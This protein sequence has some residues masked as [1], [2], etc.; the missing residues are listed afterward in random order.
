M[1]KGNIIGEGFNERIKKQVDARQQVFGSFNRSDN[2]LRYLNGNNAWIKLSSSVKVDP[3]KLNKIPDLK[4]YADNE[5]KLAQ[6]FVLFGGTAKDGGI[7]LR[8]GLK[9]AYSL[10]DNSQGFRPMPGITSLESKNR[11][12]GSIRETTVNIKAYNTTQFNIIDLLYL[13]L[14]YTV[15]LEWGHSIYINNDKEVIDINNSNTLSSSFVGGQFDNKQDE[16]FTKIKEKKLETYGNYDAIYGKVTNFSWNFEVDGSYT[17]TLKILSLGDIIE[18]LKVNTIRKD[19]PTSKEREKINEA[20]TDEEVI[21]A[22]KNKNAITKLFFDSFEAIDNDN[23]NKSY[24]TVSLELL[25]FGEV[26][27]ATLLPSDTIAQDLGYQFAGDFLQI[28]EADNGLNDTLY[29]VRFGGFCEYLKQNAVLYSKDNKAIINIDN[30][31]DSNLIFTNQYVI[32]SDPYKCIIPNN[33]TVQNVGWFDVWWSGATDTYDIFSELPYTFFKEVSGNLVGQLMNV[34]FNVSFIIK[35]MDELKDEEGNVSLY[36]LLN[37]L[38]STINECLGNLNKISVVIDEEDNN[39]I[40]FLDETQLPNREEIIEKLNPESKGELA[41][42]EIYG[43]KPDNASFVRN[44]SIKTEI[45]NELAS[46]ITIGAQANGNAA[47][48]DATAFSQWNKGLTDRIIPEKKAGKNNQ[49]SDAKKGEEIKTEDYEDIIEDYQSFAEK[50]QYQNFD[51]DVNYFKDTL[52]NMLELMQAKKSLEE[53]KA[54]PTSGFIPL[55]L[56]L[57]LFGLSGMKIYQKFSINQQ[58]LPYNYP[59]TIEF[60]IKGISHKVDKDGWITSIESLS[61]PKN[62]TGVKSQPLP[63]KNLSFTGT[64]IGT[65]KGITPQNTASSTGKCPVPSRNLGWPK[66]VPFQSTTLT[67]KEIVNI[68]KTII[69]NEKELQIFT[70]MTVISEQL[71]GGVVSG[72]NHNYGGIDITAGGWSFNSNIHDG[73]VCA[74][75]KGAQQYHAYASFKSA[76]AAFIFKTDTFRSRRFG[77][78][79]YE[80]INLQ[81][82]QNPLN[83][84]RPYGK[85]SP[86]ANT[87]GNIAPYTF[88]APKYVIDYFAGWNGFGAR[89][90]LK[91][92]PNEYPNANNEQEFIEKYSVPYAKGTWLQAKRALG[93]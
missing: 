83:S 88:S 9:D 76:E 46:M 6:E 53:E 51:D 47:S 7:A 27:S 68:L 12:R 31:Q 35:V 3:N 23:N 1:A 10:G 11:N 17:I 52:S 90:N 19:S 33:V 45:S 92:H 78:N 44:L 41:V 77:I 42:F 39:R 93:Y 26:C 2:Q 64:K 30:D 40:Y 14:G 29:Y 43:Y 80:I 63:T 36:D 49:N 38:C 71:L 86:L 69:P 55:N 85:L 58:F 74:Y 37:K 18:S 84:F 56:G 57:D 60:L 4:Q 75:D 25:D 20:K 72:F 73:Y 13:R 65:N 91:N 21:K 34:Y 48:T 24:G 5:S 50:M 54:S 15:L 59:E 8:S 70:L 66:E 28:D 87:K 61:I 32:S 82:Y 79:P 89:Y 16:L 67:L 62:T 22:Y 81:N